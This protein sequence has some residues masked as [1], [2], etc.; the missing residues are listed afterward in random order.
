[1]KWYWI[2][3]IIVGAMLLGFGFSFA[4]NNGLTASIKTPG[5]KTPEEAVNEAQPEVTT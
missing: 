4:I 1:M 5:K 2:V 3:A